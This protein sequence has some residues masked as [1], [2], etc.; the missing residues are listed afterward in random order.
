MGPAKNYY[1]VANFSI[2]QSTQVQGHSDD[3]KWLNV[4]TLAP[5]I[6][7]TCWVPL[8]SVKH[9]ASAN[10]LQVIKAAPLPAGASLAVIITLVTYYV[11]FIR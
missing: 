11:Y 2:G 6:V 5:N 10:S 8:S 1:M 9:F 3:A 7:Q 4:L